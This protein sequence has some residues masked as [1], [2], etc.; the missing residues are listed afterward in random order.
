MQNPLSQLKVQLF[1]DGADKKGMLDLYANPLIKGLTTN[2]TLMRKAGIT[3]YE[4]Y[5]KDVL[6]TVTAKPISFEVFSDEFAEMKR[7]ALKIAAWQKNVYVKIPITNTRRES[8]APLIRELAR[9]GVQLNVTAILTL[10]QVRTVAEAL[11]P[12]VPSVV[13]VFA[14]RIADTGR[15]P[16]PL[17]RA[18]LALLEGQPKAELLW[19]SVRE[20]LNI[21]QAEASGCRIVTVP[22]DVLAKALKLGGMDLGELS[23]DTVKMFAADAASAGFT[24]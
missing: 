15:D 11:N 13:S 1:A 7:Q 19:A 10:G 14:G 2:P 9:E 6:Q 4:T 18:A 22:H 20:V 24:L 17:M 8:S 16:M 3:D 23:L 21:W 5:A 12:A